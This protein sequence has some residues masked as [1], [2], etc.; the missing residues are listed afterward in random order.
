MSPDR[1]PPPDRANPAPPIRTP[2]RMPAEW[3]PQTATWLSWPLNSKT[4]PNNLTQ[5]QE[6]VARFATTIARYQPVRINADP[7]AHNLIRRQLAA[8]NHNPATLQLFNHPTNDAWCRDHGPVFAFDQAGNLV[9]VQ[10]RYNAWG[11]KTQPWDLD[12]QVPRQIANSLD[13]PVLQV[14]HFGEGG[15]IEVNGQGDL[16]TTESVWLNTNRN[17]SASR[18]Q[19]QAAFHTALGVTHVCWLAAG[20][21]NDDTDGHIDTLVR[22]YNRNSVLAVVSDNPDSPD[23]AVLRDNL[24]RLRAY[25][26]SD[27]TPLQVTPLPLPDPIPSPDARRRS[28]P[29]TY[30]NFL[31]LNNAVIVPTYRQPRFDNQACQ[32]IAQCFP[33]RQLVPLDASQVIL[34]GGA[35]HCLSQQQPA[36]PPPNQPRT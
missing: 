34:E 5:A 1:T 16:I 31:L 32:I 15:A 29:A 10:F 24:A 28:L 7:S 36:S 3:E 25:T 26:T 19:I 17:P 20:M 21:H 27:N 4:W 33:D 9:V 18:T 6:A 14:P 22:F 11:G 2:C 23:Y 35:W 13:L 30:A 8:H 12:A